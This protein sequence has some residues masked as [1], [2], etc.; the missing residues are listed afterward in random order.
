MVYSNYVLEST[1]HLKLLELLLHLTNLF[2]NDMHKF[3]INKFNNNFN[4]T[5][6]YYNN[7]HKSLQ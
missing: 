4:N 2:F 7:N 5:G 3:K 1:K 6:L